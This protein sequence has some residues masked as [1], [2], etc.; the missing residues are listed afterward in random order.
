MATAS[1]IERH[2]TVRL[3]IAAASS[4]DLP[5]AIMNFL[6]TVVAC[7]GLLA[8]SAAVVIGAMILALLLG[9]ISGVALA[10]ADAI[11]A[12]CARRSRPLSAGC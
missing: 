3:E 1:R 9:P 8:N 11:R 12:S 10:L 5:F 6:A 4:F 2:T 7:Y